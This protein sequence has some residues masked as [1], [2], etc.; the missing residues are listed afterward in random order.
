MRIDSEWESYLLWK[1]D[2][3]SRTACV[4]I[5]KQQAIYLLLKRKVYYRSKIW[6]IAYHLVE[7]FD[8][9]NKNSDALYMTE[10][11]AED[12]ASDTL[13]L[14]QSNTVNKQQMNSLKSS[15]PKLIARNSDQSG[16]SKLKADD[17]IDFV[18]NNHY[19]ELY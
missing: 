19:F 1:N 6:I 13:S 3:K 5:T 2:I 4:D 16:W 10:V 17:L 15:E 14:E 9:A 7:Y 18:L 11:L 12:L 8:S